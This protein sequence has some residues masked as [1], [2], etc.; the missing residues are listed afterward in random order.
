MPLQPEWDKGWLW[1]III[2]ALTIGGGVYA[3]VYEGSEW[4]GWLIPPAAYL[5]F[6]AYVETQKAK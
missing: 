5:L 3:S 1:G 2:A 4:A 6:L